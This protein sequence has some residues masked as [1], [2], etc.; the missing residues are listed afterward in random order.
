MECGLAHLLADSV[1]QM[2]QWEV[3]INTFSWP[4]SDFKVNYIISI[5]LKRTFIWLSIPQ[6]NVIFNYELSNCPSLTC[7]LL[8]LKRS[9][10]IIVISS[11]GDIFW[12]IKG[13]GQG[14][15]ECLRKTATTTTHLAKPQCHQNTTRR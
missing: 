6:H 7:T 8:Y 4:T 2:C 5:V 11:K 12:K 15:R 1:R 13:R 10:L 9:K 14:E 3:N